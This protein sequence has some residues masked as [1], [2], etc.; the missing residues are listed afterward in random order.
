M[1]DPSA[2]AGNSFPSP[3]EV[4]NPEDM[5]E[6]RLVAI[7]YGDGRWF[8]SFRV[9]GTKE[10]WSNGEF[11]D[12]VMDHEAELEAVLDEH[13]SEDVLRIFNAQNCTTL[14]IPRD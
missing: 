4:F 14:T 8:E 9:R 11:Y 1:I 13:D 3:T 6:S 10:Q 12:A 5:C 7:R 2:I